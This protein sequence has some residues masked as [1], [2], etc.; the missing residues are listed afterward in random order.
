MYK[1]QAEITVRD[2]G[3]G[4]GTGRPDSYGL[5]IMRERAEL[6]DADLAIG[7]GQPKGTVVTVRVPSR[8]A[9]SSRADDTRSE[10]VSA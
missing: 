3:R 6:I 8:H 10:K 4:L 1:R 7:P 2:D 9:S 5:A